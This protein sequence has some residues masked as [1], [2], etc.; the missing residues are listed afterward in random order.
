MDTYDTIRSYSGKEY[1]FKR[2][3]PIRCVRFLHTLSTC[4]SSNK[5]FFLEKENDFLLCRPIF[6]NLVG[7]SATQHDN[8][9]ANCIHLVLENLSHRTIIQLLYN[10]HVRS[11]CLLHFTIWSPCLVFSTIMAVMGSPPNIQLIRVMIVKYKCNRITR[12]IIR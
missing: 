2:N 9:S 10:P 7:C 11:C 3:R 6:L 12:T 8:Q 1:L 5:F 4:S